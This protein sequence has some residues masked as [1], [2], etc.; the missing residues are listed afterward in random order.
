MEAAMRLL[1]GFLLVPVLS[2]PVAA[3]AWTPKPP[4]PDPIGAGASFAASGGLV[5]LLRGGG[6]A[7][8]TSFDPVANLWTPRANL[9]D[10]ADAGAGL[11]SAGGLARKSVG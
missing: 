9:P 8:F 7:H 6:T 4:P 3:Q 11:I 10:V 5:Y 1:S 2:L